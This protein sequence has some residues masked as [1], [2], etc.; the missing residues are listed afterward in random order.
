VTAVAI[1]TTRVRV[2]RLGLGTGPL[3]GWPAPV[4][5]DDAL[6]TIDAAWQEGIRY[7]DTAPLYGYGRSEAWLGRALRTVPRAEYVISTKVGR[8]LREPAVE[9]RAFFQ[10]T[11]TSLRPIW[12]FSYAGARR[13]LEES[14][15]RMQLE[16]IDVALIHDPDDHLD[17]ALDG[18]Y[19]ALAELRTAGAL[20]AIGAGMNR[21]RAL[22]YLIERAELD[23]VLIAG[24]YTLL[25]QGALAELLPIAA[26]RG[27]S[28]I[29]GGVYN[30]GILADPRPGA[31]Y[32]YAPA[33]APLI[34]RA[35]RLKATC[36][37]HAVPLRAAALQFP[38]AHP[39]VAAVV[40]GA[41]DPE[42]V[43][44][45]AALMRVRI[46]P[47]LWQALRGEG[48]LDAASPVPVAG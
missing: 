2:T 5:E 34:E 43:R 12:D 10:G 30:S 41:R 42:E 35:L 8:L 6:R 20:G 25:E 28:V 15:E 7:F 37:R 24:R 9:L 47:A 29:V 36:E 46:P 33:P 44:E 23:C 11:G 14:L 26:R 4:S 32:N 1:G 17:E 3:G 48:L 21:T 40:V 22:T 39:A 27:T 45:N 31:T 13:S 19:V 38:L 18:A 16:R